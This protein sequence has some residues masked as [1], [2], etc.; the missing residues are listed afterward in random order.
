MQREG[1][2]ITRKFL[3][4]Q[5]I[6]KKNKE[7]E[8]DIILRD[9]DNNTESANA[10]NDIRQAKASEYQI[11]ERKILEI[12]LQTPNYSSRKTYQVPKVKKI[13][14]FTQVEPENAAIRQKFEQEAKRYLDPSGKTL[15]NK[16]IDF[17][18]SVL[19]K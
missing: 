10:G 13:N 14:Q 7:F 6:Y 2:Y 9:K 12:G 16:Q 15:L 11:A 4:K 17:D 1:N 18:G 3:F 8:K 5:V 19:T